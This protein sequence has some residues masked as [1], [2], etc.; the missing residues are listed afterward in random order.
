MSTP[1]VSGSG[2][3]AGGGDSLSL[4]SQ[5]AHLQTVTALHSQNELLRSELAKSVSIGQDLQRSNSVLQAA[6]A[7]LKAESDEQRE[8][9][10]QARAQAE[11]AL[12]S[13]QAAEH[14]CEK[15][16]GSWQEKLEEKA[17]EF[18]ALTA[19][20]VPARELDLIRLQ[21]VQE[22]SQQHT[23]HV[24]ELKAEVA[25]YRELYHDTHHQLALQTDEATLR[26]Q[27]D[28]QD[29]AATK[30]RAAAQLADLQSKNRK[31]QELVQDTTLADTNKRLERAQ[32]ELVVKSRALASENAELTERAIQAKVDA[33]SWKTRARSAEQALEN[34]LKSAAAAAEQAKKHNN[35][36]ATELAVAAAQVQSLRQENLALTKLSEHQQ[37]QA[38]LAAQDL[39]FKLDHTQK[40][41]SETERELEE[42]ATR[43]REALE[44][45]E[46]RSM[47]LERKLA[48]AIQ[49]SEYD[50]REHVA[51][52]KALKESHACSERE[53][54]HERQLALESKQ[55]VHQSM[56]EL[57]IAKNKEISELKMRLQTLQA[58]ASVLHNERE[59]FDQLRA[60][61]QQQTEAARAEMDGKM[62]EAHE[63]QLEYEQLQHKYRSLSEKEHALEVQCDKL[64]LEGDSLRAEVMA[65]TQSLED[66]RAKFVREVHQVRGVHRHDKA[67]LLSRLDE[68]QNAAQAQDERRSKELAE[69]R[70]EKHRYKKISLSLKQKLGEVLRSVHHSHA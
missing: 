13:K 30:A 14:E 70:Q 65:A 10:Q 34:A 1:V 16:Y 28:Q 35:E 53:L 45:A 23:R 51:Q 58:E 2:G 66:E 6:W 59:Q 27:A 29:L 38:E 43:T 9:L 42:A 52:V 21:I 63:L 15:L 19:S 47:S 56:L 18:A 7:K 3:G 64:T 8:L 48:D 67:L 36:L 32:Q 49:R 33:E 31:L 20:M 39:S 40:R 24:E 41:L 57:E 12:R 25:K 62:R 54:E 37:A 61:L 60:D 26:Q 17:A 5:H 11:A 55:H 68:V 69:A 46:S 44:Q 50:T 22:C 4:A